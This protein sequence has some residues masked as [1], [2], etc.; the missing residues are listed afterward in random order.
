MPVFRHLIT[1]GQVKS[2]T[3]RLRC[4][5]T[6]VLPLPLR[7]THS[8]WSWPI[9][10]TVQWAAPTSTVSRGLP[11]VCLHRR[12]QNTCLVQ[13]LHAPDRARSLGEAR[14]FG[15]GPQSQLGGQTEDRLHE[16]GEATNRSAS[17]ESRPA[18]SRLR[19]NSFGLA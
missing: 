2:R 17:G 5:V 4:Q 14:T 19:P 15:S 13:R 10:I 7:P 18:P 1:S 6:H 9:Q 8:L 16:V 3:F 11:I 12:R